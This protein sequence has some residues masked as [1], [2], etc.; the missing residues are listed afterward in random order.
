[1]FCKSDNLRI[2]GQ[3]QM[4]LWWSCP[5]AFKTPQYFPSPCISIFLTFWTESTLRVVWYQLKHRALS[6]TVGNFCKYSIKSG[7]N[8]FRSSSETMKYWEFVHDSFTW[9][10]HGGLIC[11]EYILYLTSII[12]VRSY[13]TTSQASELRWFADLPTHRTTDLPTHRPTDPPSHWL[14]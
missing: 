7:S 5:L 10:G 12:C 9:G 4:Y 8:Q 14:V 11:D 3:I 6:S 1:M 2:L 13:P